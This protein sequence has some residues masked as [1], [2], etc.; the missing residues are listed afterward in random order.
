MKNNKAAGPD[1]IYAEHLK[2]SEELLGNFW[3]EL[4]NKC[5]EMKAIPELWRNALM[6]ILYKG[7]GETGYLDSYKGVMLENTSFKVLIKILK[8]RLTAEVARSKPECQ[9]G[10]RKGRSTLQAVSNLTCLIEDTLRHTKRKYHVVFVDFK[11]AFDR[12]NRQILIKKL[13]GLIGSTDPITMLISNILLYNYVQIN[14]EVDASNKT[15]KWRPTGGSHKPSV[16]QHNHGRH[17]RDK[18]KQGIRDNNVHGCI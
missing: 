14:E 7:K 8:T 2:E 15:D 4:I 6:I 11:K 9:F 16:I 5:M 3:S 12:I 1:N 10:F 13:G 18:K 17:C